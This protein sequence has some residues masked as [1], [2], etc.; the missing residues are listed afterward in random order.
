M[1]AREEE[2]WYGRGYLRGSVL[3]PYHAHPCGQ[4]TAVFYLELIA[5]LLHLFVYST[6]FAIVFMHYGLPL[7]LV[8]TRG[9]D[10]VHSA[11]LECLA[12][13]S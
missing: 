5:D 11:R 12:V 13:C 1:S 10:L 2:G 6:F 4:G 7:H 8:R 9:W 3:T